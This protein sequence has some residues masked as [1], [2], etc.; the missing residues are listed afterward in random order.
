MDGR[1]EQVR[2]ALAG[3]GRQQQGARFAVLGEGRAQ[4]D[5]EG[6]TVRRTGVVRPEVPEPLADPVDGVAHRA[7]PGMGLS[8]ARVCW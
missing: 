1:E 7:V 3:P 5:V 2:D 8:R 6:R 4:D